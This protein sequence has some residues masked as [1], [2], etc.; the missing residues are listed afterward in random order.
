LAT[1]HKE[2]EDLRVIAMSKAKQIKEEEEKAGRSA[3]KTQIPDP[4]EVGFAKT[5][6][7]KLRLGS[8]SVGAPL[9]G[10]ELLTPRTDARNVETA[11][12][13]P[14]LASPDMMKRIESKLAREAKERQEVERWMQEELETRDK[15][16]AEIARQKAVLG[17]LD[18]DLTDKLHSHVDNQLIQK[19]LNAKVEEA[20]RLRNQVVL[21][22]SQ[23][24]QDQEKVEELKETIKQMKLERHREAVARGE[25]PPDSLPG[26]DGTAAPPTQA[27]GVAVAAPPRSAMVKMLL[28]LVMFSAIRQLMGL[29]VSQVEAAG[30][31]GL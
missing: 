4:L 8:S 14:S 19:E 31:H 23:R 13:I 7:S 15:L 28:I 12:Q 24:K 6:V 21:G 27:T 26:S 20:N 5:Q 17:L 11:R 29:A 30:G 2:A 3:P 10:K 1:A 18:Q 16:L 25:E 22:A 9:T